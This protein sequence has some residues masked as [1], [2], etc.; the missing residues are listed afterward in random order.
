MEQWFSCS[1]GTMES[2]FAP[3]LQSWAS[4]ERGDDLESDV[5][6]F[7]DQAVVTEAFD[8]NDLVGHPGSDPEQTEPTTEP[9]IEPNPETKT[10]SKPKSE[11]TESSI[12]PIIESNG[13]AALSCKIDQEGASG[14]QSAMQGPHPKPPVFAQEKGQESFL[15]H[16]S[17]TRSSQNLRQDSA[18]SGDREMPSGLSPTVSPTVNPTVN[19]TILGLKPG[20]SCRLACRFMAPLSWSLLAEKQ[21]LWPRLD[22]L[23]KMVPAAIYQALTHPMGFGVLWAAVAFG[24]LSAAALAYGLEVWGRF[25]A[26]RLCH[27][28]RLT[29]AVAGALSGGFALSGRAWIFFLAWGAWAGL[30]GLSFYHV[31]IQWHWWSMPSFCQLSWAPTVEAFLAQPSA[32]CDQKTLEIFGLPASFWLFVGALLMLG[33]AG[34]T[35]WLKPWRRL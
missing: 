22:S 21:G 32:R 12:E 2:S 28:E 10:V 24:A 16:G 35:F 25:P 11:Y 4:L 34:L 20:L 26:C 1:A 5:S 19:P 15:A 23:K 6:A 27:F 9:R 31:G 18:A 13:A 17:T 3:D 7:K 33:L 8:E 14:A 30:A 29:I